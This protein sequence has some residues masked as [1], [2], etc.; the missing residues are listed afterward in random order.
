MKSVD[1][2][3]KLAA[4]FQKKIATNG[5]EAVKML[6]WII[7]DSPIQFGKPEARE[8]LD[9]LNKKTQGQVTEALVPEASK[10][11]RI[12]AALVMY[13]YSVH[14]N[15]PGLHNHLKSNIDNLLDAFGE[16]K[17]ILNTTAEDLVSRWETA[18]RKIVNA[19]KGSEQQ[20]SSKYSYAPGLAEAL[21]EVA[22]KLKRR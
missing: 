14:G 10:I 7:N 1:R 16:Y 12:G 13:F 18:I 5:S 11:D 20:F 3:I 15:N 4:I 19:P 17:Y 22:N 21:F 2:I 6:N 9:F 8:V